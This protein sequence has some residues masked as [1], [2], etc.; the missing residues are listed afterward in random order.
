MYDIIC[1]QETKLDKYD[2]IDIND[3][4][5]IFLTDRDKCKRESG[6]VIILTKSDIHENIIDVVGKCEH[7]KWI[8]LER[9][10]VKL[11]IGCVYIPPE[12]STY[13]SAEVFE[14]LE[15]Y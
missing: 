8:A 14:K 1:L 2:E 11:V 7:V 9:D 15:N 6:G 13:S 4:K 12:G 3:Y 5:V 10:N